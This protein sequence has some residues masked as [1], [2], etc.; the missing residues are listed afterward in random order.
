MA[1]EDLA[2]YA[3]DLGLELGASY[4]EARAQ[5]DERRTL[6]VKNGN[7]ESY[8]VQMIDGLGIRVIFGE[9]LGFAAL[10]KP[11]RGLLERQVKEAISM[12]RASLRRAERVSLSPEEVAEADWKVGERVKFDDVPLEEKV[13]LALNADKQAVEAAR[14][15]ADLPSR[16]MEISEW[17]TWKYYVNSEGAKVRS[18]VP[19]LLGFSVLTA[20]KA[21]DSEQAF[22]ERGE[23]GG[24]EVLKRIRFFEECVEKAEVLGK[25]LAEGKKP[26]TGRVDVV[27]GTEVVGLA[28]H[29]TTGHP[30]ESDRILGRE[31]AQAGESFV[32]LDMLG[33]RIGS[34]VA[35]VVDDPTIENSFGFYLYDDEGVRARP[36]YLMKEGVINELLCNRETAAALGVPSNA[37]ARASEYD[38]EPIVRMGNTY[39]APGDFSLEE[40]IEGIELGVYLKTFT[41][42]NVDDVRYN[43]KVVGGEAYLIERGELKELVR[44]P[45]VEITTPGLYAS[46]DAVGKEPEFYSAFCGKGDPVQPMPVWIG[47]APA[48]L[49]DVR[50]GS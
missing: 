17:R 25:I 20:V 13:E 28:V 35:T 24:W 16:L 2:D 4:V 40:L 34:E 44:R 11:D 26:P 6:I 45:A 48:R 22:I 7:V 39:L 38:K 9:G 5:A 29:E 30:Y 50:L 36:R 43:F 8:S 19:R 42:F 41:E 3:V 27:L 31:A 21:G 47:G 18:Y 32:T 14:K 12:A 15:F 23:S 46:I 33:K 37:S 49:R 10:N 1:F